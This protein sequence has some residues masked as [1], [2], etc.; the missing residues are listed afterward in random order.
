MRV[1]LH[2]PTRSARGRLNSELRATAVMHAYNRTFRP[3]AARTHAGGLINAA[4]L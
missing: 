4:L 2:R 3:R 1:F